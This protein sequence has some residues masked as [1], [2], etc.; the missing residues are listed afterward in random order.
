MV[1]QVPE[2]TKRNEQSALYNPVHYVLNVVMLLIYEF[3]FSAIGDHNLS[4]AQLLFTCPGVWYV[5]F[6]PWHEDRYSVEVRVQFFKRDPF[7]LG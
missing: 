3:R 5:D 7:R 2:V 6:G 1:T 4:L